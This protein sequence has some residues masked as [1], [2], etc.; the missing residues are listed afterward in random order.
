MNN[1]PC[2]AIR[3]LRCGFVPGIKG[4]LLDISSVE[5]QLPQE[6]ERLLE[7]VDSVRRRP[8]RRLSRSEPSPDVR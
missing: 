5:A 4:A 3:V 8:S 2:S 1:E 6:F 7:K